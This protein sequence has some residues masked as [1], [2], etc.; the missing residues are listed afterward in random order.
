MQAGEAAGTAR[1]VRGLE[2][3][4][5][6]A[7][8]YIRQTLSIAVARAQ[9]DMLLDGLTWVGEDGAAAYANRHAVR[10]AREDE[11]VR[12]Q[13][14]NKHGRELDSDYVEHP[15]KLQYTES[16][17]R[18][19]APLNTP[20]QPK[21]NSTI[22]TALPCLG[23]ACRISARSRVAWSPLRVC[24][25]G[26]RARWGLWAQGRPALQT[27]RRPGVCVAASPAL[28]PRS[29]SFRTSFRFPPLSSSP[30]PRTAWRPSSF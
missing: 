12:E 10:S 22:C 3:E 13:N 19:K 30:L 21:L 11:A 7:K 18:L 24:P 8:T 5:G 28:G 14:L 15:E 6:Q 27:P 20:V 1:A 9:A 23:A 4:G 17:Y 25:F 29:G 2:E 26:C 16:T